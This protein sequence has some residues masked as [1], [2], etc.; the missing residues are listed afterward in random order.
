VLAGGLLVSLV[1]TLRV[2]AA[3]LSTPRQEVTAVP[4]CDQATALWFWEHIRPHEAML[5]AWLGARF[6]SQLDVDDILQEAYIRV[7]R[8]R[9]EADIQSPK[10]FLFATA[11]NLSLDHMRRHHV[12]KRDFLGEDDLSNVLDNSCDIRD[13]VTRKEERALLTEAIQTLPTRCRQVM[14]LR[15]VYGLTQMEI[16]RQ[17]GISDRTVA[18]QLVIGTARCTDYVL[19]RCKSRGFR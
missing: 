8:A 4:P 3:W 1:H 9:V 13:T 15:I 18:A 14:T 2:Q 19:R 6:G 17:L 12:T 5:R 11:R 10:A 7:C 16:G